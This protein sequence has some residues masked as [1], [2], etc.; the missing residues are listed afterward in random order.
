MGG[1]RSCKKRRGMLWP[2]LHD[3]RANHIDTCR[4]ESASFSVS[5]ALFLSVLL[6]LHPKGQRQHRP[7][8]KEIM[9]T[10]SDSLVVSST[11]DNT[12]D[13]KVETTLQQLEPL[14][15]RTEADPRPVILMTCGVSGTQLK[16]ARRSHRRSFP[17]RRRRQVHPL[18]SPPRPPHQLHPSLNGR[19]HRREARHL[20]PGLLPKPSGILPRRSGRHLPGRS[21]SH[22]QGR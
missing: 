2:W 11:N 21:R 13:A 1:W 14:L 17:S 19:Y 22:T 6:H 5:H 7:P 16:L 15:Q 20:R 3:C 12:V 8:A 9:S 10:A 18:Q 4:Y